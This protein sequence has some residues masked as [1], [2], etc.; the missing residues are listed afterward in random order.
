MLMN[1]LRSNLLLRSISIT[2][3]DWQPVASF[4][5]RYPFACEK[6]CHSATARAIARAPWTRHYSR[7]LLASTTNSNMNLDDESGG[8]ESSSK[9]RLTEVDGVEEEN[10]NPA[11]EIINAPN[12][13]AIEEQT[14]RAIDLWGSVCSRNRDLQAVV[15]VAEDVAAAVHAELE[16]GRVPPIFHAY[17]SLS[18]GRRLFPPSSIHVISAAAVEAGNVE[19]ISNEGGGLVPSFIPK[20]SL[21][22]EYEE[23]FFNEL[24]EA[25]NEVRD[26]GIAPN[27]WTFRPKMTE[28]VVN[29]VNT[30]AEMVGED[31]EVTHVSYSF[32]MVSSNKTNLITRRLSRGVVADCFHLSKPESSYAIVGC[33]VMGKSWT[34]VYALQQALLYDGASSGSGII[35]KLD[36]FAWINYK[37]LHLM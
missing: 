12:I 1:L 26:D 21:D 35:Q 16:L 28:H 25:R 37:I 32:G 6:T 23:A 2:I 9:R 19:T 10:S 14:R 22:G 30:P 15:H 36:S 17:V 8:Q 13:K 27:M 3:L 33:P 24:G 5:A 34:L 4:V 18:A 7:C 31:V 11:S 29:L 20:L